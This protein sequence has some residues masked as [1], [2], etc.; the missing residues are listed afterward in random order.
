MHRLA[1][2]VRPYA[3][4]SRT[5]LAALQ[6]RPAPADGP[7]AELWV[8]AH[9]GAPAV[10]SGSGEPLDAAILADPDGWLG[11]DVAAEFGPRLPFLLKVLAAAEPLSFQAHPSAEQAVA[12]FEAEDA[13]GVARNSPH[14]T[15][16]DRHHK[17]EL[18]VAIEEFD[19]LCGFRPPAAAADDLAALGVPELDAVV[20]Q[21]RRPDP[22]D[23][24]RTAVTELLTMPAPGPLVAATVRAAAGRPGYELIGELAAGY[25][26]D[27]GVVLALMLNRVRLAP[28]EAVWM[29]AGNMHMY[30]RGVGVEI[31]AASDNVLRGGLTRKHVNVP[32][33]L[34]VLRFE[35]LADPVAHPVDL[36][37]GLC[38]WPVPVPDFALHRA[39]V[40]GTSV[41]LPGT[42][43]RV[44]LCL[45]GEV[46]VDDGVAPVTLTA[47]TAAIARAGTK[48][49]TVTGTGEAYQA[50]VGR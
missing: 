14:R 39:I 38:T 22:A 23:A 44:V 46:T 8:G 20:A 45:A 42:G 47:G 1:A 17:P 10:L 29:P 31:M 9:P 48:S 18:L 28:G 2:P 5:A 43:P 32:E 7:E 11:P 13:A 37:P 12:G 16:V 24:L 34:R 27:P 35:V 3:W 40:A 49:L 15:Y 41:D 19:V 4:G 6:G 33:L 25:P 50:G 26:S 21:L 30:M 36:A